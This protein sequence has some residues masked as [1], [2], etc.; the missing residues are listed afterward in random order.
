[1]GELYMGIDVSKA[2][3]DYAY[4]GEHDT[5]QVD[6]SSAGIAQLVAECQARQVTLVVVEATGSL[7]MPVVAALLSAGIPTALVNPRPVR[8]FAKGMGQLAKTDKI[9]AHTLAHFGWVAKPRVYVLP[10][11]EAQAFE[12]LLTRRNQI[13][14]MLTVER[15][16]LHTVHATQRERLNQHIAWL[17]AELE[18]LDQDLAQSIRQSAVW[19]AKDQ[20]IQSVPGV[21][22][23]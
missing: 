16:R 20:L 6:H 23:I 18:Q 22:P 21:G 11:A 15:M 9:D 8:D 14:G 3:L 17:K 12:A 2:K 5:Q 13:L 19:Q 1:M 4:Y 10:A 7:E